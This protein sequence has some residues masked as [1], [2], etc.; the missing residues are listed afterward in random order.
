MYEKPYINGNG[1]IPMN[2]TAIKKRKAPISCI[3]ECVISPK[4]GCKIENN[5]NN[6]QLIRIFG[7]QRNRLPTN[8]ITYPL[9][10]KKI[11][12]TLLTR[13]L[14]AREN[15]TDNALISCILFQI[16]LSVE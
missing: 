8:K 1:S 6:L 4:H 16:D 14:T 3:F 15:K 13:N 5:Y 11:I 2:T 10:I 12:H 9:N 7:T